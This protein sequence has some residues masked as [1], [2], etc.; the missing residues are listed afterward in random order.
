MKRVKAACICQ[1]LQFLYKDGLEPETGR[2]LSQEEASH[3]KKELERSHVKYRILEER[4]LENGVVELKVMKQYN[5][6]PVG[7]YLD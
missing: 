2:R 7:D 3:Y 1:T 5:Q 4:V 6:S